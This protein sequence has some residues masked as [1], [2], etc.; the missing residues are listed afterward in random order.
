MLAF[1]VKISSLSVVATVVRAIKEA[2]HLF[3]VLG[4][5]LSS[6][7]STFEASAWDKFVSGVGRWLT[8]DK[9]SCMTLWRRGCG[10]Q[11]LLM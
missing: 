10:T 7:F 2:L 9:G 1:S 4:F 11:A 8:C 3:F 5:L 6:T